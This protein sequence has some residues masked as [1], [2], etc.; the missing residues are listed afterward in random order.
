MGWAKAAQ[1]FLG[2]FHKIWAADNSRLSSWPED[3][4][5]NSIHSVIHGL[6]G[7]ALCILGS[8]ERHSALLR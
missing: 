3:G 6:K 1:G 7:L 4:V 8:T 2:C 5:N